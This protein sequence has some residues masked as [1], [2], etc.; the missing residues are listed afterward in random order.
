M[1]PDQIHDPPA[2]VRQDPT[3][4]D[5]LYEL[6]SE[7]Q[8]FGRKTIEQKVACGR[9]L[10]EAKAEWERRNVEAQPKHRTPWKKHL[11]M[12]GFEERTARRL[13]TAARSHDAVKLT[14]QLLKPQ[15]FCADAIYDDGIDP[16]TAQDKKP[17]RDCRIRGKA[18]SDK[19]A[20]CRALNRPAPKPKEDAGPLKDEDGNEVPQHLVSVFNEGQMIRE[21]GTYITNATKAIDGLIERPGCSGLRRDEAQKKLKGLKTYLLKFRPGYVHLECKGE[22][23]IACHQRGWRTVAEV[24]FERAKATAEKNREKGQQWRNRQK[25]RNAPIPE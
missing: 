6:M 7:A 11:K 3:L 22:G 21:L 20:S 15:V 4:A 14:A 5:R 17:C 2:I 13:M 9:K 10:I 24:E 16:D 18:F 12:F 1:T 8:S 19:C 25:A 23:C